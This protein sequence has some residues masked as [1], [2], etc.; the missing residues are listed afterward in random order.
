MRAGLATSVTLHALLLGVGMV[1]LSAPK[2]FEVSDVESLPVEIIPF[3]EISQVQLGD[4]QA[5]MLN[6]PA[7]IPTERPDVVPDAQNVG[8]AE[9]DTDA[10]PTPDPK[11]RPVEK[12]AEPAPAPEPA[13]KPVEKPVEQAQ[14]ELPKPAPTPPTPAPAPEPEKPAPAAEAAP[15]APAEEAVT[16][17]PVNENVQLPDSAPVPQSRPQPPQPPKVAERP[18]PA[19]KPAEPVQKQAETKKEDVLDEVAA[20]LNKEKPSGGGA[21]RSNEQA[22]LGGSRSNSGEKLSQSEMDGLRSQIQKCWIIPAGAQDVENLRV[23]VQFKLSADGVV[24]GTPQIISGGGNSP[25]L[26]AA[27]ESAR[28]AVLRCG[29]YNLPAEKYA[30]WSEIKVN[31]DPSEMF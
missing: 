22:A 23:S 1:S 2:A 30:D 26:R 31:F 8:E 29:P 6:K 9:I 20:L 4:K 25:V 14:A 28:R 3:D 5:P 24:E 7:P 19:E 15:E 11:P 13:P 10:P 17:A 27:A 21:Q 18:K 12:S 16:E